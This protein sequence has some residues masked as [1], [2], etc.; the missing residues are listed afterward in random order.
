MLA[1]QMYRYRFEYIK[2]DTN[3]GQLIREHRALQQAILEGDTVKASEL[4]KEHI[5]RQEE[6]I[7]RH[8]RKEVKR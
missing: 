7:L 2:D 4:A 3:Y 1:D 5:D 8:L 6:A